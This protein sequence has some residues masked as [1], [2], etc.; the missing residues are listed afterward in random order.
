MAAGD[1]SG[2]CLGLVL[3]Q[4]GE[5]TKDDGDTRVQRDT[6]QALRDT[7]GDVLEVHR[8]ALDEHADGD[9][10]VEGTRRGRIAGGCRKGGEVGC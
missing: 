6:H 10:R 1:E 2:S 4:H 8:L 7:V 9:Y 3:S 5:D